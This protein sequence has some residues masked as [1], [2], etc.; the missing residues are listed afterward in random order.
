LG[1]FLFE[2]LHHIHQSLDFVSFVMVNGTLS[3]DCLL[4]C[5]AVRVD[6]L[7][8]MLVTTSD[9]RHR[10]SLFHSFIKRDELVVRSH[11][12]LEMSPLAGCAEGHGTI[13]AVFCGLVLITALTHHIV[14]I[15]MALGQR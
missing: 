13:P 10:S 9:P 15:S 2:S 4:V 3:A 11:L 12:R 6:L 1:D 14:R 5:L 8:W 7:L